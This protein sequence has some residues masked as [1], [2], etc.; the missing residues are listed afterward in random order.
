MALQ[1]L[2]WNDRENS[3]NVC[4]IAPEFAQ[5]LLETSGLIISPKAVID[6]LLQNRRL[7]KKPL[8]F[9]DDHVITSTV[10][11]VRHLTVPVLKG[12]RKA[13]GTTSPLRIRCAN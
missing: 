2:C 12:M 3:S 4:C 6:S 1:G 9:A 8:P 13:L 5:R 10:I 7:V 11:K